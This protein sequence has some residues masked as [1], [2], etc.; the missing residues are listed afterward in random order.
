MRIPITK[1]D[2][3]ISSKIYNFYSR[4]VK[5]LDGFLEELNFVTDLIFYFVLL[6]LV[7]SKHPFSILW[8]SSVY[9]LSVLIQKFFT[10]KRPYEFFS[11]DHSNYSARGHSFPSSHSAAATILLLT[12]PH[13]F[14]VWIL[15]LI[16]ILRVVTLNHWITDVAG[17]ILLA[18]SFFVGMKLALPIF[19]K[20]LSI[21]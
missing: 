21:I 4:R 16:P 2:L 5:Y 6:V 10:R 3:I 19:Q 9:A 11:I 13:L 17:G 14:I 12:Y 20:F 1:P 15:V 18:L 7:A 8:A